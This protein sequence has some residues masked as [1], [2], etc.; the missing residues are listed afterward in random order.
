MFGVRENRTVNSVNRVLQSGIK[1]RRTEKMSEAKFSKGM[2][3]KVNN[4]DNRNLVWYPKLEKFHGYSGTVVSSE[5]WSTYYLPGENEPTDIFSYEVDFDGGV[6]QDNVP[7]TILQAE[8][9]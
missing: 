3:V 9:M 1:K 4:R 7:E 2:K 5:F 8:N 6:T